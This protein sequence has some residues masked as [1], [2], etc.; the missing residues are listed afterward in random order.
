MNPA[1]QK[2]LSFILLI[3]VGLLLKKK[4]PQKEQLGGIKTLIL[5]IALPAMIFI[6]LLKVK[7]DPALL[8]LPLLA[9]GFNLF[10]F[11]SAR[12]VMT[13]MGYEPGSPQLRTLMMLMP[14]LAPGLSCFPF[15]IEY[16]GEESLAWAALADV[17]NKVFGLILLYLVAM[18][19]YQKLY[20]KQSGSGQG[21]LKGLV[22]SLIKE[23]VNLVIVTAILFLALG[24]NMMTLPLFIQDA[25]TRMSVLMTPMI[26]IFIGLAVNVKWKEVK[27][28]FN[29]LFWRAGMALCLSAV[30]LSI[31]PAVSVPAALVL[32]VFPLSSCS[33][34]PFAHMCAVEELESRN[35]D[36]VLSTTGRTF[37]TGFALNILAFSL[38]FS[39]TLILTIFS[40]GETFANPTYVGVL[41]ISFLVICLIPVLFRKFRGNVDKEV[42]ATESAEVVEP[43]PATQSL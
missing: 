41:G 14:S 37:D 25:I 40:L 5:S 3:I 29:L 23:P 15:I 6:A 26:L 16:L 13:W 2:T 1:L 4:I 24:W 34:W 7:V 18:H 10:M 42:I 21:R 17:G 22:L 30:V 35:S 8:S 39:T 28:I 33:F 27:M 38:P 9:L 12:Y 20:A 31:I 19:W 11:F 43:K 36:E 32:V